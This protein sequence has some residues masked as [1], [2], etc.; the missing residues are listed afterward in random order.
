MASAMARTRDLHAAMD[1]ALE[2]LLPVLGLEVGGV[3]LLDARTGELRATRYRGVDP[4]YVR[5]VER[6]SRGEAL[7]GTALEGEVPVVVADLSAAEQ[8]REATRNLGVRSVAFVP[9]YARGRAMGVM[10]VGSFDLHEFSPDDLRLLSAVGGM[11]GLAI[12]NERL[13]DQSRRHLAEVRMLWEI[14][15]AL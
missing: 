2:A 11:L 1:A 10:P 15:R 6:F 13:A 3:Y 12:D 8:A 5:A 14:D 4:E 7:L 9:L